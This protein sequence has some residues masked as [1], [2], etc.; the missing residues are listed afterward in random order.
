[1]VLADVA[2]QL[3]H[4]ALAETHYLAFGPALGIKIAAALATANRQA[5]QGIFEDL[6]ESEELDDPEVNRRVKSHPALVGTKGAVELDAERSIDLN[7]VVVIL[8]GHAEDDL[9]LGLANTLGDALLDKLRVF[10][11]YRTQRVQNF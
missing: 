11:Q 3:G 6:L 5:G 9:T 7:V 2:I 4:Q 8:P 10:H 1:S